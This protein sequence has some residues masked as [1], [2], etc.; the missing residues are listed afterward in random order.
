MQSTVYTYLGTAGHVTGVAE[1]PGGTINY[2]RSKTCFYCEKLFHVQL[3]ETRNKY[4][5]I[6]TQLPLSRL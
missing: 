3:T 5:G 1:L 4:S 6:F 2:V